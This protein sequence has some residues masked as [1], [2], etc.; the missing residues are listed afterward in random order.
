MDE[1]SQVANEMIKFN[2][3]VNW[4]LLTSGTCL[5]ICSYLMEAKEILTSTLWCHIFQT[6]FP[7]I[8]FGFLTCSHFDDNSADMKSTFA[9]FTS[10]MHPLKQSYLQE[11]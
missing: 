3:D 7:L 11:C 6:P 5:D 8:F 9:Q 10:T 1:Y 2:L 4:D